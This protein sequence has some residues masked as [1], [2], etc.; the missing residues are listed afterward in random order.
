M[1]KDLDSQTK[2]STE[3]LGKKSL[4]YMKKQYSK[5]KNNMSDH[6][7]NIEL[8]PYGESYEEGFII[9]SGEDEVAVYNEYGTGIV[10]FQSP[11][12][13]AGENGYQ[14]N[15]PSP[16][17]GVIPEMAK[18]SYTQQ[19]LEAV[20]TPDTWWYFK[21]GKW[22]HTEGMK[23][24]NMY[25]SLVDE[26]RKNAPKEYQTKVDYTIKKYGGKL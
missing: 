17:K 25:A 4:E 3:E 14:Y 11:S 23:G 2:K 16:H 9:S 24:K 22:W 10:G 12:K 1:L 21:N 13:L 7:S 26:L 18:Y 6:I 20:N 19:Y 5:Q 15:V 8:N